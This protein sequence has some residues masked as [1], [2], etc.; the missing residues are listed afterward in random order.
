M[1]I[2]ATAPFRLA[3]KTFAQICEESLYAP[4]QRDGQRNAL[5]TNLKVDHCVC[6]SSFVIC[7]FQAEIDDY[8][9][10][11]CHQYSYPTS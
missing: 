4:F 5:A 2:S 7:S 9:S 8:E 11:L 6:S 10:G 3:C 1:M